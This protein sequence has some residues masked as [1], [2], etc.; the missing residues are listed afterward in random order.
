MAGLQDLSLC[1]AGNKSKK[2]DL[3]LECLLH[4]GPKIDALGHKL[5][6]VDTIS[7]HVFGN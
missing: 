1:A 3:S 7:L 6:E 2:L 5:V 4:A